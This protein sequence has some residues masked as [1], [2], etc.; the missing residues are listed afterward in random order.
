MF[1]TQLAGLPDSPGASVVASYM[2]VMLYFGK[3]TL[4][5]NRVYGLLYCMHTGPRVSLIFLDTDS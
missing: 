3:G 5:R 1:H 2:A 4:T